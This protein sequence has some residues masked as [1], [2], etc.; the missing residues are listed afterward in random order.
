M[1]EDVATR[2]EVPISPDVDLPSLFRLLRL[3]GGDLEYAVE[4]ATL[5]SIFL[6][7]IREH[8]V[9]EELIKPRSKS[10]FRWRLTKSKV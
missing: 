3:G 10:R 9:E 7:V 6:K 2:Y 1:A 4:R 5:E 8:Q